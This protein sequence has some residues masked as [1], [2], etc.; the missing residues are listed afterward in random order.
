[1]DWTELP[2]FLYYLG[3]AIE[4]AKEVRTGNLYANGRVWCALDLLLT[5]RT[6]FEAR[7]LTRQRHE[8]AGIPYP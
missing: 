2:H 6:I 3:P 8:Q 5:A 7:D 1:M 4:P